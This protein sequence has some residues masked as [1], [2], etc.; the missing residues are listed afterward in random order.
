MLIASKIPLPV[1]TSTVLGNMT[2]LG[3]SVCRWVCSPSSNT[4][5]MCFSG[6]VDLASTIEKTVAIESPPENRL[7]E[8]CLALRYVPNKNKLTVVVSLPPGCH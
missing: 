7:G 8:V 4:I 2:R 6:K 5:Q 1:T 3:K